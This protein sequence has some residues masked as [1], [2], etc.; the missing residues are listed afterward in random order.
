MK[1]CTD[2]CILGAWFSRRMA[3]GARVL[4]IGSGTGLLMLMLAQRH[5]GAIQGIEL[6]ADACGQLRENIAQS[7]WAS[8]LK[9]FEGDVR[10]I[11][12]PDKFDLIISNPPFFE[13][14][15][16]AGS[17]AKN[18]ARHSKA[19]NLSE[20]IDVLD[21]NLARAGGFAVLLPARRTEYFET[22]AAGRGFHLATR[23]TISQR[24]GDEPFRMILQFSRKEEGPASSSG[25]VIRNDDGSYTMEFV[26]LMKDYYLYSPA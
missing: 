17:T 4:D 21:A 5:E 3:A 18:L 16:A 1:V 8:R 24:P 20:L 10:N 14:D 11:V 26:N 19:L 13:D 22:L 15:L 12:F 2:A 23:L 7:P 6:D 25:L 9:V